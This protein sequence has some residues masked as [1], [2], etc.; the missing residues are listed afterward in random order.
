MRSLA[1][2]ETACL[3]TEALKETD[4]SVRREAIRD[5]L[6]SHP[7]LV[8]AAICGTL[9]SEYGLTSQEEAVINESIRYILTGGQR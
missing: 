3:C 4:P 2:V 1:F 8:P 9:V 7:A 5:A 6:Q